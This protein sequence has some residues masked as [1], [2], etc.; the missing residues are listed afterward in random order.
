M[1]EQSIDEFR[2][3]LDNLEAETDKQYAKEMEAANKAVSKS[4]DEL[5]KKRR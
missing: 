1:T 5:N 3:E 2:I 4:A